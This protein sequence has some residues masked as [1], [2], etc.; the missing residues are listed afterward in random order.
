[1]EHHTNDDGIKGLNGRIFV[2]K[3][4]NQLFIPA[5]GVF[6]ASL[7]RRNGNYGSIWSSSLFS[8]YPYDALFLGFISSIVGTYNDVRYCGRSIRP[9]IN[10]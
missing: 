2:G 10:L 1:M 8:S 6:K 9:V 4:G 5:A 3:N 7:D